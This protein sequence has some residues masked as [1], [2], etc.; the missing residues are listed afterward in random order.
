MSG[1]IRLMMALPFICLISGC[2]QFKQLDQKDPFRTLYSADVLQQKQSQELERPVL[3]SLSAFKMSLSVFS[4]I[5]SD[6]YNIGVVYAETLS[7]K[8]ITGEFKNTDLQSVLNVLSRQLNVDIVRVGNTYFIGPLR[9]EDRGCFVRRVLGYDKESLQAISGSMLSQQGKSTVAGNVIMIADHETVLR[10]VAE[11]CDYLS[12]VE[13]PTWIVQLYFIVL[14]KDALI[15]AGLSTTSSGAVS[16]NISNSS[17][18]ADDLKLDGLFNFLN[19]STFA[20]LYAAP[21]FLI[22]DGVTCTWKDGEHVP[23]P[24]KTVSDYGTVT[25]QGYDYVDTGLTVNSII[26]ESKKGGLLKID[27]TLS[28]IK[29]YVEY[30]PTTVQTVYSFQAD[31]IPEKVYLVGELANFKVLDEQ[32]KTFSFTNNKGK[33]VIQLWAKLYKICASSSESYPKIK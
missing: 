6:K 18:K 2:S 33:T 26:N 1:F 11:L 24:R 31:L 10:R 8:Q 3:L 13:R 5:L 32:E 7:D 29:S 4:R 14:R 22:T 21:M 19:N 12:M 27:I 15:Q 16:Y 20:D 30:A 28:E 9:P 17:V 23:I 25:T